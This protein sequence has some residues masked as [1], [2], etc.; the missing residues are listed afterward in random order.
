MCL[1]IWLRKRFCQN[2]FLQPEGGDEFLV[3]KQ[4]YI[5]G[6]GWLAEILARFL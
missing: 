1:D 2:R 4:K 5:R 3:K 6:C